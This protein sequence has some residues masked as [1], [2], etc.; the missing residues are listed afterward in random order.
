MFIDAACVTSVHDHLD[1]AIGRY[2]L[3]LVVM[4]CEIRSR[5]PIRNRLALTAAS[6]AAGLPLEAR[7]RN[8]RCISAETR[9]RVPAE[10]ARLERAASSQVARRSRLSQAAVDCSW[11]DLMNH[12]MVGWPSALARFPLSGPATRLRSTSFFHP[13]NTF[14]ANNNHTASVSRSK[15]LFT[16]ISPDSSHDRVHTYNVATRAF[17]FDASRICYIS[18]HYLISSYT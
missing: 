5:C 11:W 17:R 6:C 7:T 9:G 10:Y 14:I 8:R 16:R 12:E 18:K 3:F 1:A 15:L 4:A 13:P 2:I